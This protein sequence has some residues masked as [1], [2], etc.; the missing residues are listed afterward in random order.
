M[1]ALLIGQ[2]AAGHIDGGRC[3]GWRRANWGRP[4]AAWV[5][6]SV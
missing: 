4:D 6:V 5:A 3:R 1:T 2:T